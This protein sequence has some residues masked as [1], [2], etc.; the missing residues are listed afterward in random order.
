M[1]LGNTTELDGR[2]EIDDL[3]CKICLILVID[4]QTQQVPTGGKILPTDKFHFNL[5]SHLSADYSS[6]YAAQL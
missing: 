6:D 1:G 3:P 4:L 5:Y 2:A